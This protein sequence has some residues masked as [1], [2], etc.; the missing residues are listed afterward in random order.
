MSAP[1]VNSHLLADP[2]SWQPG[3]DLLDNIGGF[4]GD[5]V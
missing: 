5:G 2:T 1:V 3:L 4:C